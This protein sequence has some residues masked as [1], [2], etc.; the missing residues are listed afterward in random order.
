MSIQSNQIVTFDKT[1]SDISPNFK[2]ERLTG[3]ELDYDDQAIKNSLLNMFIIQ[4]GEVAGHPE[5]GNPLNISTF[6]LY[7]FFSRQDMED[8][9]A[10]MVQKYEPRVNLI[11]IDVIAAPEYNRIV[12]QLSYSY[13]IDNRINYSKLE[14]P[15]SHNSITYLGGRRT[16]NVPHPNLTECN[17][18]K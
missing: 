11:S 4:K 16:P 12:I 2:G 1:F 6:D 15:Y 14:I 9:I 7:S 5:F 10:D 18:G 8:A 17:K 3:Y 13:R